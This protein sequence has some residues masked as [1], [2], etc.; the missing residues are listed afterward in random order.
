MGVLDLGFP[1]EIDKSVFLENANLMNFENQ[2]VNKVQTDDTADY[3]GSRIQDNHRSIRHVF[4]FICKRKPTKRGLYIK[5]QR[6]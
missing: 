5:L 3:R 6:P 4:V 1:Q 2:F